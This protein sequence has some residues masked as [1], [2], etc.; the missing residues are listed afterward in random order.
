[1]ADSEMHNVLVTGG[2][3]FIGSGLVK[4]L[5]KKGF[6]VRVFDN[7]FRGNTEN[8][9][10][11]LDQIELFEGDIRNPNDV[12]E[13]VKGMKTVYHLAFINGTENFYNRPELVLDVGVRGHLNICDAVMKE[14]GV[15]TFIYASSSEIYQTPEQIPTPEKV[16]GLVPD[17]NNPRYSYGGAKLMG[18]ILTLHYLK[19]EG[20]KK[21]IFRP[22]NIYGEAMGFEHV[23]P[24]LAK[25]I[26]DAS[27]GFKNDTAEIEIQGSGKETRAFCYVDDAVEGIILSATEGGDN[28]VYHVGKEEEI[29]IID[30]LNKIAEIYN[31]Q[32]NI[33][34]TDL[35]L[36]ST[37]RRC[38]DITKLRGLGYEPKVTLE[39]GLKKTLSWYRNYY[40]NN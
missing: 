32:L 35:Q 17:V 25:K 33:T 5:V 19:K 23:I 1:M 7:N 21:V 11:I 12:I 2:T 13:A 6:K 31:V 3:G 26:H 27:N 20:L 4:G 24:Q 8:I 34:H 15:E 10:E 40:E 29:S 39:D 38:P 28:E 37:P 9:N 30:L 16:P 36:G 18:E 22:H 14:N